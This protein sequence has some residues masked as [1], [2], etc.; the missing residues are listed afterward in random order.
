M[1]FWLNRLYS[2]TV[3]SGKTESLET[4]VECL[5]KVVGCCDQLSFTTSSSPEAVLEGGDEIV[6]V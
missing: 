1:R 2:D 6:G 5:C 3:L 4:V